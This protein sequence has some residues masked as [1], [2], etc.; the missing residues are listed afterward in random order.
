MR[1]IHILSALMILLIFSNCSLFQSKKSAIEELNNLVLKME[2]KKED[3]SDKDLK[4]YKSDFESIQNILTNKQK[5]LSETESDQVKV[6]YNNFN[7]IESRVTINLMM[8]QLE[9]IV[10]GIINN[11]EKVSPEQFHLCDSLISD[12]DENLL[13][14]NRHLCTLEDLQKFNDL[15]GQY[16]AIKIEYQGN[17]IKND[18]LDKWQQGVKAFKELTE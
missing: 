5:E 12:F 7:H 9:D 11:K 13:E 4:Q 15:K 10:G 6:L 1:K 8:N 14:K 2:L 17:R 16:L 18:L 3:M